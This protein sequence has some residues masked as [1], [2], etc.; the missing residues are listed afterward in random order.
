MGS[1]ARLLKADKTLKMVINPMNVI[2]TNNFECHVMNLCNKSCKKYG[3]KMLDY[4]APENFS[5]TQSEQ[6][7]VYSLGC[8][9]YQMAVQKRPRD[10]NKQTL[11]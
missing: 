9:C 7:Q 3:P 2:L 5:D 8:I 6:A 11:P 1:V 4:Y 10:R